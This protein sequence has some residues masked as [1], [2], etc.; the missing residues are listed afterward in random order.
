MKIVTQA[1]LLHDCLGA[2]VVARMGNRRARHPFASSPGACLTG[3]A[4]TYRLPGKP[5]GK[6]CRDI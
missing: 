3:S 1:I 5:A 2:L 4:I 6:G